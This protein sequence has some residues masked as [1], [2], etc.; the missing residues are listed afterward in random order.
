MEHFNRREF[1]R[2]MAAGESPAAVYGP[3]RPYIVGEIVSA[4][5]AIVPDPSDLIQ[6]AFGYGHPSKIVAYRNGHEYLATVYNTV[7]D[8]VPVA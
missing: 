1:Y 2:A 8:R 7:S 4:L 5:S 6:A 3:E